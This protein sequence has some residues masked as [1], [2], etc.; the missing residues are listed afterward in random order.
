MT[1][2]IHLTQIQFT[3]RFDFIF[4]G[5]NASDGRF[6]YLFVTC[7]FGP[8]RPI[9]SHG[10]DFKFLTQ[11]QPFGT[12]LLLRTWRH[13]FLSIYQIIT[14]FSRNNYCP[15]VYSCFS[16]HRLQ[17]AEL[18]DWFN[19][20][21]YSVVRTKF[22]NCWSEHLYLH[23]ATFLSLKKQNFEMGSGLLKS[24]NL[25][26]LPRICGEL[27]YSKNRERLK[28]ANFETAKIGDFL[29]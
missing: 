12:P 19:S 6:V 21:L 14:T 11:S 13:D 20:V 26:G 15:R 10:N 29:Y 18:I 1:T 24:V 27:E 5:E 8:F 22:G 3:L 16:S 17:S 7:N 2:F 9:F 4:F 28:S 23:L 25:R